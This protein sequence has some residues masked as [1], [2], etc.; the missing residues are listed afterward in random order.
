MLEM[1]V[2]PQQLILLF[3]VT[4]PMIRGGFLHFSVKLLNPFAGFD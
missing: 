3:P 2:K 4:A 1:L